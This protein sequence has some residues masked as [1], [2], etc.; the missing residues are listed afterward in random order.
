MIH[1]VGLRSL[2]NPIDTTTVQGRFLFNIFATL[3]EFERDLMKERTQAGLA[4]AQA[5]DRMDG[6][7][8]G[9]SAAAPCYASPFIAKR[10][11]AEVSPSEFPQQSPR[12]D[13]SPF[14]PVFP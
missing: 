9:L 14:E 5:R 3:A 2:Q 6:R 11:L 12:T 1:G 13:Q 7:T 10:R 4:A 8:K